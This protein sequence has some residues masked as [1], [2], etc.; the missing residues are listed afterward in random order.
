MNRRSLFSG[1]AAA[2]AAL[3]TPVAM[4]MA[5][6]NTRCF[7][8][9]QNSVDWTVPT[10]VKKIR[11]QSWSKDGNEVIDTHFSVKPGQSFRIEVAK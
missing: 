1:L 7:K 3:V 2:G 6:P 8:Q 4:A 11:V 9:D 10:N 5:A